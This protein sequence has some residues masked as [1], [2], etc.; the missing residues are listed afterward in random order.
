[1]ELEDINKHNETIDAIL[2]VYDRQ[3]GE[4][5]LILQRELM[6]HAIAVCKAYDAADIAEE[7]AERLDY[8]KSK[9]YR[10]EQF[11]RMSYLERETAENERRIEIVACTREFFYQKLAA[12]YAQDIV[13]N[14]GNPRLA[15]EELSIG[16]ARAPEPIRDWLITHR[17]KICAGKDL[18]RFESILYEGLDN[19][20]DGFVQSE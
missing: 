16:L 2:R 8:L 6:I 19:R 17:E 15:E 20:D 11:N 7:C 12:Q 13:S 3:N 5:S 9:E 4:I 10:I 18:N 14:N 1:M